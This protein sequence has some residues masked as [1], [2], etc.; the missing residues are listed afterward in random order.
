MCVLQMRDVDSPFDVLRPVR[1]CRFRN[2][3][4]RPS[5]SEETGKR[6]KCLLDRAT[7]PLI[8]DRPRWIGSKQV[9]TQLSLV[10]LFHFKFFNN[11]SNIIF[12]RFALIHPIVSTMSIRERGEE[13]L[14][15][16]TR[17]SSL[18]TRNCYII[19][20]APENFCSSIFPPSRLNQ[21]FVFS[22]F[23]GGIFLGALARSANGLLLYLGYSTRARAYQKRHS[24]SVTYPRRHEVGGFSGEST[25]RSWCSLDRKEKDERKGNT[26]VHSSESR[27]AYIRCVECR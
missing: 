17:V 18:H 16:R 3:I 7:A 4:S 12:T 20:I 6:R 24:F 21:R 13:V 23:A 27:D 10:S 26:S 8:Q 14:K 22:H 2:I 19:K 11:R 5:S 1:F 9:S 25:V 15:T